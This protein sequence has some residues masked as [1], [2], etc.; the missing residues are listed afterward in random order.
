VDQ[1][2]HQHLCLVHPVE[3]EQVSRCQNGDL[4]VGTL[5]TGSTADLE[6]LEIFSLFKEPEGH[7]DGLLPVILIHLLYP[8]KTGG[9]P[10][11]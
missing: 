4:G 10:G 11:F 1:V 8:L 2:P 6:G 9:R 3:I 5:L 7:P